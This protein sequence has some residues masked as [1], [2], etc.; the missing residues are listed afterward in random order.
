MKKRITST[1]LVL[2]MVLTI[3][4][5]MA[6]TALAAGTTKIIDCGTVVSEN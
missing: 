1:L 5:A 3:I 4:P 6:T 2:S